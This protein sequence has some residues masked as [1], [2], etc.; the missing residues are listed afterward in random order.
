[1]YLI[2]TRYINNSYKSDGVILSDLFKLDRLNIRK[3][4]DLMVSIIVYG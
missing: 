3:L 4:K 1:M 2:Y